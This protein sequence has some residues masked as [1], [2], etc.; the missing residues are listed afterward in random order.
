MADNTQ[1]RT[2]DS[3][4]YVDFN[5][6]IAKAEELEALSKTIKKQEDQM[7]VDRKHLKAWSGTVAD[8]YYH[9][10]DGL[11]WWIHFEADNLKSFAD[12]LRDSAEFLQNA[13][14]EATN[15]AQNRNYGGNGR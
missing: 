14:K 3:E 5:D 12:V 6:L 2:D 8:D 10:V 15:I 13:E 1:G 4:L 11:R 7:L 9:K